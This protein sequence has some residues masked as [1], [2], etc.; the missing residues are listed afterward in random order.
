MRGKVLLL[1]L[2]AVFFAA[3]CAGQNRAVVEKSAPV[4]LVPPECPEEENSLIAS[5]TT[6]FTAAQVRKA[7]AYWNA[8]PE[9]KGTSAAPGEGLAYAELTPEQ[10]AA[11][12]RLWDLW[13][14][15][16]KGRIENAWARMGKPAPLGGPIEAAEIFNVGYGL[17]PKERKDQ[18][19]LEF[20]SQRY[21]LSTN[22]RAILPGE[23]VLPQALSQEGVDYNVRGGVVIT[24][25]GDPEIEADMAAA[26]AQGRKPPPLHSESCLAAESGK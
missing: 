7:N 9:I 20:T 1:A 6:S 24:L 22:F 12:A 2:L 10:Q 17:V 18:T 4:R 3:G 8:H 15:R 25:E 19:M 11:F 23:I 16:C 13:L 5:L 26:E 14:Q 21:P